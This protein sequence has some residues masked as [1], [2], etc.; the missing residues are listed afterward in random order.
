MRDLIF[1]LIVAGLVPLALARPH[2]AACLW[3]WISIMNPHTMTFGF[4]RGLP[5]AQFAAAVV[6]LA[7]AFNG[8]RRHALPWSAGTAFVLALL[9][10]VTVTSVVS[11]NAPSAVWDRWVFFMK[12]MVMMLLSLTLVRG[13]EQIE[14][15]V[16]VL[17]VSVGFFGVKGGVWTM[18]TGGGGRVWGPPGGMMADNNSIAIGLIIVL[19]WMYYLWAVNKHPWVKRG[20]VL[21]MVFSALA[22]LGTQSR[23]ALLG[24]LA[25]SLLL[26]L[27][28]KHA[29]RTTL[30]IAVLVLVGIAFMPD[31]WTSRMNTIETYSADNSA[32]SRLWTWQ[33]LWNLALDRPWVGGGFQSDNLLVFSTYSPVEGRGAF[34]QDVYVAHSIYFQVLGEHGFPGLFFYLGIGFWTWFTAA[35]LGRVA[36]GQPDYESWVP[37][38]MRMCQVSLAGFAVGGAFLSLMMLDLS[39]YIFAIVMLTKASMKPLRAKP[40]AG[41]VKSLSLT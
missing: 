33:T 19:P 31:T 5:W 41:V 6:F 25:M 22:V 34:S 15:L 10:W 28:S 27:K 35:K 26:G 13:R 17:V 39:Y 23:G 29:V 1:A 4:A 12:I 40:V 7:F 37:L 2:I 11:I 3:A 8:R 20:L 16:W 36:K 9:V 24:L 14:L 18:L 21:S 38:L 32:M 30:G